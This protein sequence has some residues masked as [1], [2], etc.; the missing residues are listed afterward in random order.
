DGAVGV[1]R[2]GFGGPAARRRRGVVPIQ[3]F[4][5]EWPGLEAGFLKSQPLA[6]D[7]RVGLRLGTAGARRARHDDDA[8]SIR[9][10]GAVA[11]RQQRRKQARRQSEARREN[12]FHEYSLLIDLRRTATRRHPAHSRFRSERTGK[13]QR[14]RLEAAAPRGIGRKTLWIWQ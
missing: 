9:R 14:L 2:F 4:D 8:L 12:A 11:A 13:T 7:E 6:V 3:E 5:R 10:I 1:G